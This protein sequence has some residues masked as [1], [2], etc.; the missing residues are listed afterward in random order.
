MIPLEFEQLYGGTIIIM[1]D[2]IISVE[3]G[4]SEKTSIIKDTYGSSHY[5]KATLSDFMRKVELYG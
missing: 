5:V 2:K 3:Q 1:L 4:A